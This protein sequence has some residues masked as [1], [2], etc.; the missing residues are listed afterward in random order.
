MRYLI[1]QEW[2][3]TKGNH[4]GVSYMCDL[5]VN[6]YPEK[7]VKIVKDV[8]PAM[9]KRKN[10]W[11]RRLLWKFDYWRYLSRLRVQYRKE[12]MDLCRSMFERLS[13]NDEVFL[14]EYNLDETPQYDLACYVR[15]HYPSVQ[16]YALSH[17]TPSRFLKKN[18][19]KNILKWDVPVDRELTLGHSLASFFVEIGIPMTKISSG[20]YYVD[21]DYYKKSVEEILPRV[22]LTIITMGALQRDF[23]MLASIV[24]KTCDKV[25]WIV[26]RGRNK[27]VDALFVSSPNVELKGFM[28]EEELRECMASA[29]VSLNVLEDTVGSNVITSSLAM[30]LALIVSDVGSIRDYCDDSNAVFCN[31]SIESFTSAIQE[32]QND[33]PRVLAMRKSSLRKSKD[34]T[35]EKVD[36]WFDTLRRSV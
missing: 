13:E 14:L 31:N 21:T 12:Y 20:H 11:I 26:C 30:G 24:N 15:Q 1:A 36:E 28:Q 33:L 6:R 10:K 27:E 16:I 35:I 7:Y 18:I 34:F 8:P 22:N 25:N 19:A 29:D 32:L 23:S 3:S 9:Y 2:N 4:A 5:L 17:L